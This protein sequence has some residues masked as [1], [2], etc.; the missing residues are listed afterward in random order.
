MKGLWIIPVV[1]VAALS[2]GAEDKQA[3][4]RER[5][6]TDNLIAPCC[7]SQ[8][9]SE[10]YSDA[11]EQIRREV[12]AMVAAGKS[13]DEILDHYV[14]QY[15]ERILATPR[16]KGFNLL[17]YLL[18]CAAFVLGASFLILR[19]RK[20]RSPAPSSAPSPAPEA[21]YASLIKKEMKELEE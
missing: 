11:A 6:I 2:V 10:H 4:E 12:H 14:A 7:W 19:I 16:A 9:V 3:A 5:E 8:T 20:L 13:R 21:R 1:L 15:G 18:P 17:V